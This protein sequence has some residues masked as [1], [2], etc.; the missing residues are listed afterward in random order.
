[1]VEDYQKTDV[2]NSIVYEASTRVKDPV[3][4]CAGV[5]HQLQKKISELEAQLAATQV[6]VVSMRSERDE[7]ASLVIAGSHVL[8]PPQEDDNDQL[9][10][11][12]WE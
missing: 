4:G 6:E 8:H 1:G 3:H 2:V 7:L 5:V 12:L 11:P 10:E 9:L